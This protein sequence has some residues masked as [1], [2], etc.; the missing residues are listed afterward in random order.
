MD[1]FGCLELVEEKEA[2]PT[3]P[4][5]ETMGFEARLEAWTR[6]CKKACSI[7]ITTCSSSVLVY[8]EGIKDP[9]K[10]W[11][12]LEDKFAPKTAITRF[13]VM[14]EFMSLKAKDESDVEA[15]I[16]RLITLK[17]RLEEQGE[18]VSDTAY[19]SVLMSS[20]EDLEDYK[21]VIPTLESISGLKPETV[22]N[23][24][25]E[26]YRK[27]YGS[28]NGNG[29]VALFSKDGKSSKGSKS[30][31]SKEKDMKCSACEKKGHGEDKY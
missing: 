3:T 14:K 19:N 6:K 4:T 31:K 20:V 27:R 8:L 11:K 15:H 12:A 28:G 30:S 9:V 10:M 25:L 16:Q 18:V 7:I 17:M 13:Q 2:K 1:E 5:D 21:N 24:F 23:R 26:M 29:K 22:I